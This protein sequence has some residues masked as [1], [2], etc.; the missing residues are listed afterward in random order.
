MNDNKNIFFGLTADEAKKK[1]R[2]LAMKYHPDRGGDGEKFMQLKKQ[3]EDYCE[4]NGKDR[5]QARAEMDNILFTLLHN[6]IGDRIDKNSVFYSLIEGGYIG[7]LAEQ[8]K[9]KDAEKVKKV[10]GLLQMI[11]RNN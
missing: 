4:S 3:Y 6:L 5:E 8:M 11:F 1:F 9:M 2:R 10:E 7:K